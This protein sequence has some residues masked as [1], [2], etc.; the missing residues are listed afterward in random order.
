LGKAWL[1]KG[2]VPE[3]LGLWWIQTLLFLASLLLL[4]RFIGFRRVAWFLTLGFNRKN[5]DTA[6]VYCKRSD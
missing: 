4:F 2:Q 5:E 1:E 6:S 3:Y